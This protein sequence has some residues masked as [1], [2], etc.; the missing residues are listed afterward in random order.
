ML[1]QGPLASLDLSAHVLYR[2]TRCRLASNQLAF[3]TSAAENAVHRSELLSRLEKLRR[4]YDTLLYGG[5]MMLAVS[6]AARFTSSLSWCSNC[7]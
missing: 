2:L 7:Q 3:S 6:G 1:L 5:E 4:E